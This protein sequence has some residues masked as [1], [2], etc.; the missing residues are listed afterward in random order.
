MSKKWK[1]VGAAVTT[2]ALATGGIVVANQAGAAQSGPAA[3]SYRATLI[4]MKT[5]GNA[6]YFYTAS[7]A[8]YNRARG[9]KFT[10]TGTPPGY[11]STKAIR[12]TVA[13]YRLRN[14]KKSTYLLTLSAAERD[15][16]SASKQWKYEGIV[17]RVP[18]AAAKD[19]VQVFRVSK[20]GTGGGWRVV[21][22]SAVNAHKKAGWRVD[23]PMGYVWTTR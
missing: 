9:L 4:E 7:Q 22:A 23:G 15:K 11:V 13:V 5:V 12:G 3:T 21:R 6:G 17:G 16:L 2:A 10:N 18:V 14:L 20:G 1:I 19:R 8:E